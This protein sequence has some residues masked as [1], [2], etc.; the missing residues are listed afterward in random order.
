MAYQVRVGLL[1]VRLER[2]DLTTRTSTK[3]SKAGGDLGVGV[4]V[5]TDRLRDESEEGVGKLLIHLL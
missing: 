5:L 2:I 4:D 1:D 3:A